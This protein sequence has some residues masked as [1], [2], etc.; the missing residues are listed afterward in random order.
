MLQH[1]THSI[2]LEQEVERHLNILTSVYKTLYV[3]VLVNSDTHTTPICSQSG[4]VLTAYQSSLTFKSIS[5][6]A[7]AGMHTGLHTVTGLRS[8][9]MRICW[10]L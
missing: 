3:L 5:F 7:T 2:I 6:S 1:T 4:N 10:Q 8:C 9:R